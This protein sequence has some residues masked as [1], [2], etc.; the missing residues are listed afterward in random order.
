MHLPR[1]RMREL[2]EF[3]IDDDQTSQATVEKNEVHA[4]PFVIDAQAALAADKRKV[5]PQL[6]Q[7]ALKVADQRFL[8]IIFRVLI[9]EA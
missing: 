8:D 1:I 7:K 9:F 6:Q 5:V 4:V 3:Q 2:S